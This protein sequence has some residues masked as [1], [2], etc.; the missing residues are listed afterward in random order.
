[1]TSGTAASDKDQVAVWDPFV[2]VFHWTLVIGFFVAYVTEDDLLT[3]HL[4]A[5]YTVGAL[6]LA[7]LVWGVVGPQYA[8]FTSFV[9]APRNVFGYLRDLLKFSGKRYIGHSPAGGAMVLTLLIM[10]ILIVG[11]G[12]IALALREGSGPLAGWIAPNR[13][14]GRT[15]TG[16]HEFFANLTLVLVLAHVGGV[17]FASLVH[18]ENLIKAMWTGRKPAHTKE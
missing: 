13:S 2:R 4:V 1:M 15:V 16:I 17:L 18:G 8:R 3:L 5:G 11:S 14:L 9:Y 6:V 7:R 10:L 12:L